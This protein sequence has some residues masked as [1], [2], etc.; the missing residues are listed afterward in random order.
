M[1][2]VVDVCNNKR[3]RPKKIDIIVEDELTKIKKEK[4]RCKNLYSDWEDNEFNCG[5][6]KFIWAFTTIECEKGKELNFSTLNDLIIYYNRDNKK[7]FLDL[8]IFRR[9]ENRD[10]FQNYISLCLCRFRHYLC[11]T[12]QLDLKFDPYSF[13]SYTKGDF[14]TGDTLTELYY[15][16]K[17]FVKGYTQL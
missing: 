14:F 17:F 8:D 10:Q 5:P 13:E 7:Y 2:T 1:G 11:S 6:L 3:G 4:E 9:F 15:K 16:F 12:E